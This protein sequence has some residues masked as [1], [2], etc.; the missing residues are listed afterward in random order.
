MLNNPETDRVICCMSL[1]APIH[2]TGG[3]SQCNLGVAKLLKQRSANPTGYSAVMV[4]GSA[5]RIVMQVIELKVLPAP[6]ELP[7]RA[8]QALRKE[9]DW[10][11][12]RNREHR[13]GKLQIEASVV[14]LQ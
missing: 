4:A 8:G 14:C 2:D 9:E 3:F 7:S 11:A 6:A 12:S 5:G 10:E 13:L 1:L